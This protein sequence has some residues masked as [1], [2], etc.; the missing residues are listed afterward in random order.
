MCGKTVIARDDKE[1]RMSRS[2]QRDEDRAYLNV[3]RWPSV[4]QVVLTGNEVLFVSVWCK[5]VYKV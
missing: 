1:S 3:R 4:S 5:I 2:K